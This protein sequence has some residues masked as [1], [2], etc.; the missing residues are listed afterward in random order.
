MSARRDDAIEESGGSEC[1]GSVAWG[2]DAN[3]HLQR[4]DLPLVMREDAQLAVTCCGEGVSHE[5]DLR[6]HDEG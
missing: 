5:L 4:E 3:F 2:V 1:F 6:R